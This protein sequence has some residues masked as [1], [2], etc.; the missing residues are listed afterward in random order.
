MRCLG[1]VAAQF[2]Q[3][4]NQQLHRPSRT[5]EET[6]LWIG[7]QMAATVQRDIGA[8]SVLR[9]RSL[10]PS[11][12]PASPG[13]V[14]LLRDPWRASARF[15]QGRLALLFRAIEAAVERAVPGK[16]DEVAYRSG[17]TTRFNRQLLA[18][19]SEDSLGGEGATGLGGEPLTIQRLESM[20]RGFTFDNVARRITRQRLFKLL[21]VLRDFVRQ[22]SLD[23]E[24]TRPGDPSLWLERIVNRHAAGAHVSARDLSDAWGRAFVLR[25]VTRA[26]FSRL[27]P[28]AGYE[29]VSAGPDGRIGS[30]DDI[31]DPTR[32][33]LPTN[34]LYADAVG[35]SELVARLSGVELGR[36]TA[37][38][39]GRAFG[40]GSSRVPP[41]EQAARTHNQPPLPSLLL[42]NPQPLALIRPKVA[43]ATSARHLSDAPTRAE[44]TL[45][46]DEEPRTWGV[47]SLATAAGVSGVSLVSAMG[48]APV[49]VNPPELSR[50]RVDEP[51]EL[52]LHLTNVT[53]TP[54][55]YQLQASGDG[56]TVELP[57]QVE[58]RPGESAT[59]PVVFSAHGVGLV[60]GVL[61]VRNGGEVIRELPQRFQVDRG[62]HPIRRRASMLVQDR[63]TV[64]FPLP[65]QAANINSRLLVLTGRS[66]AAD[67]E[68]A[69]VRRRDPALIAW[70][71]TMAGRSMS[72]EL[73][74][75]LL[76]SM[77][78]SNGVRG[79]HPAVSTAAAIVALAASLDDQGEI[80][81]VAQQARYAAMN[82][83]NRMP[84]L[85]DRDEVAAA[86]R[87]SAAV[88]AALSTIGVSDRMSESVGPF[89]IEQWPT[90]PVSGLDRSDLNPSN[91]G[92]FSLRRPDIVPPRPS[93]S[94]RDALRMRL[95]Q[96][97]KTLRDRPGEPALLARSAAALLLTDPRDSLGRVMFERA[98]QTLRTVDSGRLLPTTE[99]RRSLR[100]VLTGTLALAV[101]AQQLGQTELARSLVSAVSERS[102]AVALL[103]GET[104][105]WW[106][107]AGAYGAFGTGEVESVEVTVGRQ[108]QTLALNGG[109]ATT[110]ISFNSGAT[111][112]V[113]LESDD[114]ALVRVES[115]FGIPFDERTDGPLRVSMAG[116]IGQ[117]GGVAAFEL[118]LQASRRVLAPVVDV[119]LPAGV[120][121]DESFIQVLQANAAVIRA[122]SRRP[123]FLR[124]R[125]RAMEEDAELSL[126]LPL[127][128]QSASSVRGLA[129]VAYEASRPSNMTILEPRNL[130]PASEN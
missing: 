102:S 114:P 44:I 120:E 55:T 13:Q 108:Q 56:L 51:L 19:I 57:S 82:A 63:F 23:L 95:P 75:A 39:A 32:R 125:L 103:G 17:R 87:T 100:E 113:V 60:E 43:A 38:V 109:I 54:A 58:V 91:S 31:V 30:G 1:R 29:L 5:A 101:A 11:P 119:Q 94:F 74:A 106:L 10:Q 27:Q 28:V 80:D 24:W 69:D 9:G 90:E 99:D 92:R 71:H 41:V 22:N 50:L 40:V 77:T 85:P 128:W 116:D 83:L 73:R 127:R 53:D 107:A 130:Q 64:D 88:V 6:P 7:A 70:A 93:D 2:A 84:L 117:M 4:L 65:E 78:P 105:F 34:S 104:A 98:Q 59:I 61:R 62:L 122:Q 97:R 121:I 129:V 47:V 111:T 79:D 16:F 46:V 118:E 68:L 49:L 76:R 21:L 115:V 42:R 67:P 26:R 35:E 8:A 20:D 37:L 123:G 72:E 25:P 112:R 86:T 18:G 15:V 3:Q 66:L 126:P 124:L 81:Q 33:V 110:D 12:A 96:L 36:V 89:P 14:G 48:G 45:P 52:Q